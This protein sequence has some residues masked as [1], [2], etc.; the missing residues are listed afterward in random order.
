MQA[1]WKMGAQVQ[2]TSALKPG[3]QDGQP[4][5]ASVLL[6]DIVPIG[7][8]VVRDHDPTLV[9]VICAELCFVGKVNMGSLGDQFGYDLC[10]TCR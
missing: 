4:G 10:C 1:E 2:P 9:F 7:T 5:F 8:G 6:A 3:P